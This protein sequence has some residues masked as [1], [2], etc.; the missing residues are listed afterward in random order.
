MQPI[1]RQ[2]VEAKLAAH[3]KLA[4]IDA[5]PRVSFRGFHLPGAINVP[6]DDRNLD[7]QIAQAVPDKGTPVIVYC[8]NVEC[9]VSTRVARRLDELGYSEVYDYEAGKE[10]WTRAGNPVES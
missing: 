9:P 10:D 6:S 1:T 7:E 3:G 5:L 2:Q 8:R 4:L